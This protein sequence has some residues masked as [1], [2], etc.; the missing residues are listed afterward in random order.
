MTQK[1]LLF[2]GTAGTDMLESQMLRSWQVF[3]W[4]VSSL[5]QTGGKPRVEA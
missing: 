4:E 5:W 2:E 3:H 1:F